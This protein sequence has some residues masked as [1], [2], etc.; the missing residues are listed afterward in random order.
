MTKLLIRQQLN[1]MGG[2]LAI[3]E[4]LLQS[5]LL[6]YCV[7]CGTH[8][9]HKYFSTNSELASSLTRNIY[10]E[11]CERMTEIYCDSGPFFNKLNFQLPQ[12]FRKLQI[13]LQ[14]LLVGVIF[15]L[16]FPSRIS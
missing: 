1:F 11:I 7:T 15:S 3:R 13:S 2:K 5:R 12:L 14:Q 8:M 6:R 16:K 9:E 4:L 10:V